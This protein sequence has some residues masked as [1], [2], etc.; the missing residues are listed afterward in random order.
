MILY[1][2]ILY[3]IIYIWPS[4]WGSPLY[5]G[6]FEAIWQL[7]ASQLVLCIQF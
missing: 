2:T 5:D 6:Q 3:D 4:V 7:A 1:H